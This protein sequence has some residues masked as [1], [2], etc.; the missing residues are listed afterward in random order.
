MARIFSTCALPALLVV[1]L[2]S[3]ARLTAQEWS[4]AQQEVIGALQEYTRI[5]MAGDVEEIMSHFHTQFS[6]WDY[7]KAQPLSREEFQESIKYYF[8]NY[9][10]T[11]FDV[12]PAA[13]QVHG[14][15]A[16]A[17]LY[18]QEV[19]TDQAGVD[20][21]MSGPWTAALLKEERGWVFLTWLWLQDEDPADADDSRLLR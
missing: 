7:A 9:R 6:A 3:P 2:L 17:H 11:E 14:N 18:Y 4:Q 8:T 12:Q 10:Q 20:I 5:S 19:F 16:I 1:G 13:I 21:P 15:M